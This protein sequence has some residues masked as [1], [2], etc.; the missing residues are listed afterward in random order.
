MKVLGIKNIIRKDV[1][2]YY[3]MFFSGCACLEL[4]ANNSVE[5]QID[6]SIEI[7]PTGLKEILVVLAEPVDYPLVPLIRALKVAIEDLDKNGNLPF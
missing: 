5:R 7:K 2:I 4:V 6:F 3:R 1:P